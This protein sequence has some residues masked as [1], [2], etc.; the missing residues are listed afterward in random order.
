M[1]ALLGQYPLG[2]PLVFLCSYYYFNMSRGNALVQN[3]HNSVRTFR[4][5]SYNQKVQSSI[6][7]KYA[8]SERYTKIRI[9]GVSCP[10]RLLRYKINKLIPGCRTRFSYTLIK[11]CSQ[12]AKITL[13]PSLYSIPSYWPINETH[14]N[15]IN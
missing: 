6:A 7:I 11:W 13:F 4:Q 12:L 10:V 15:K 8:L 9:C 5:R 2:S 14:I 1:I 3:K